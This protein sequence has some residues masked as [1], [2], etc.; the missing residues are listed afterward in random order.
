MATANATRLR[1][2]REAGS[3]HSQ[4]KVYKVVKNDKGKIVRDKAGNPVLGKAILT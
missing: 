3:V 4:V 2:L 1:G